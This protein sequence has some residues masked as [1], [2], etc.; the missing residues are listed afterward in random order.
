[1]LIRFSAALVAFF[2]LLNFSARGAEEEPIEVLLNPLEPGADIH[3]GKWRMRETYVKPAEGIEPKIGL[4][5]LTFGGN[6]NIKGG[7]ADFIVAKKVPGKVGK[8]SIE[9][10]LAE[11]ANVRTLGI[12]I[13]DN[14]GE[15]FIEHVPADW[16]GWRLLEFNLDEANYKQASPQGD[17]NEVIDFPI[18]SI[19]FSWFSDSPGPT[20]LS[21]DALKATTLLEGTPEKLLDINVTSSGEIEPGGKPAASLFVTNYGSEEQEIKVR[22]S[23]QENN[24]FYSDPL[25]D[26]EHGSNHAVGVKA[27]IE[28]D[29]VKKE[30]VQSNDGKKWTGAK[31]PYQKKHYTKVTHK[32][33]LG[34][35]RP[36]Q[37]L[38]WRSGNANAA[39]KVHV[40]A[41]LD[42][43][44]FEPIEGLQG[45]NEHKKWG[46]NKFPDFAPVKARWLK[47]DHVVDNEKKNSIA[48][49]V[50]V[51]VYD[52]IADEEIGIPDVGETL[53]EGA[54][55]VKV[56]AK[57]FVFQPLEF[58][59]VTD[60]GVYLMGLDM[61]ADGFRE[62]AARQLFTAL[63]YDPK[64][65]GEDARIA[66]NASRIELVDKLQLLGIPWVRFENGKWPFISTGPDSYHFNPGAK[67]WRLN[68]DEI[69]GAYKEHGIDVLTYMFLIP[70]WASQPGP[71]VVD[72]V[73][74]SQVP[75]ELKDYGEFCF[76][77]AARYGSKKHPPEVLKS[78][79][80]LSGLNLVKAYNTY[81]EPNLNAS[82]DA[83]RGGWAGPMDVFY[84]MMRH[85][86]EGVRRADPDAIVTGPSLAGMTVQVVDP[87]RTHTYEDGKHPIDLI[88]IICVHFYAGHQPPETAKN[89][90]NSRIKTDQNFPENMRELSAWR[91][92]YAPGKPIWMTET[93]YDSAGPFGT[94]EV[95]QA[96]RLPRQIM[97]ALAY[98][99][100]KVFVYREAGSHPRRHAAAGLMRN[101]HSFK[102]S[103]YTY[104]TLLRQF[105]HVKG[106]GVRL[107]YPENDNVWLMLWEDRGKP[108]VTAWTVNGEAT[109]EAE[110]G[111][112]TITSAFGHKSA[113]KTTKGLKLSPY[114]M[115]LKELSD[116]ERIDEWKAAYAAAEKK[117]QA[118]LEKTASLNKYLFDFGL[119]EYVGEYFRDG[120][121]TPFKSVEEDTI[122]DGG[123]GFGFDKAAKR[124]QDRKGLANRFA[125]RDSV[126]I[127]EEIFTYIA[128]PGD[129]KIEFMAEPYQ[130]DPVILSISG[131]AKTID[132]EVKRG[133]IRRGEL[134]YE[135]DYSVKEP[136]STI[137]FR[138]EGG[139]ANLYWIAMTQVSAK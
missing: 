106:G 78:E 84:E 16:T 53:D 43:E 94:N 74:L 124:T 102:P 28:Y 55:T 129:Y 11:D 135:V 44:N 25:P 66:I 20:Y 68:F 35:V 114:P 82:Y 46:V 56:P 128:Q 33:D 88:D 21:V 69:F 113:V 127:N 13:H 5:A 131:G 27:W 115:Y 61:K 111:P 90:G 63:T 72:R 34:E 71:E 98:G 23:L 45:V 50:E 54:V 110:F 60:G 87:L 32:L 134:L 89:D 38:R 62:L 80:K 36:V 116:N 83:K 6:S 19:H 18:K 42:G 86:V 92:K 3:Q 99:A 107:P 77:M 47:F 49:P 121:K 41:S 75:K 117:R 73:K 59:P 97:M 138:L 137:E 130:K 51:M 136:D 70:E 37:H 64:L 96:A 31:V 52:G 9:T 95:V 24:H 8:I 67:P 109:L 91:D 39:W 58:K 100:E 105:R 12:Q 126:K 65:Q 76:Q 1:M 123:Q 17:K 48:L 139:S 120:V 112:A 29:E 125:Y 81:N 104:G 133:N 122:W 93:G 26:P 101:D 85:G 79:D 10:H 4:K 7:K 14:E 30:D 22:Y 15:V 2:T 119:K 132:V 57:S 40:S 118:Q 103:W 108:L